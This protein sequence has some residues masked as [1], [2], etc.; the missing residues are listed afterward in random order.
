MRTR[1]D[2]RTDQRDRKSRQAPTRR[3]V[4]GVRRFVKGCC[5]IAVTAVPMLP[6]AGA[7]GQDS[8]G[9]A[10]VAGA[11][12]PGQPPEPGSHPAEINPRPPVDIRSR[13]VGR[14]TIR[15]R[16]SAI[17]QRAA[18]EPD[19]ERWDQRRWRWNHPPTQIGPTAAERLA[20]RAVRPAPP[21]GN[22][23]GGGPAPDAGPPITCAQQQTSRLRPKGISPEPHL[24]SSANTAI[25][26]FVAA[27]IAKSA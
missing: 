23:C 9:P 20:R 7:S 22:N 19:S 1:F 24:T 26:S 25:A 4:T 21:G 16:R 11:A 14:P 27:S 6:S 3:N 18:R 10:G 15:A 2:P 5:V 8:R 12:E 13:A 17:H